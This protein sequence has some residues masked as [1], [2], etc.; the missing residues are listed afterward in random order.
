MALRA[1][2]TIFPACLAIC[3]GPLCAEEKPTA[4]G[5][6]RVPVQVVSHNGGE[7]KWLMVDVAAESIPEP[8]SG[9]GQVIE[10]VVRG[11]TILDAEEPEI[12]DESNVDYA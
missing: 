2:F 7:S 10:A 11:S 4:G 8:E 1:I 12:D 5:L 6:T 3:V 9:A